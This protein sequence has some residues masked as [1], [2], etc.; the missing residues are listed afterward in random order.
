M[1]DFPDYSVE[2]L[3]EISKR[4]L[5]DKEYQFSLDA[6]FALRNHLRE[7]LQNNPRSFSNGRYVRNV[8]EKTIRTQAMR[9]LVHETYDRSD[10]LTIHRQDLEF[11]V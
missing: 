10:L 11:D 5:A 6:E 8:I 4:M 7:L 3:M 1:L 9:L 2:Q